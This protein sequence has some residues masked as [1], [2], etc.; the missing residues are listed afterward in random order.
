MLSWYMSFF[1]KKGK[2][3]YTCCYSTL[4]LGKRMP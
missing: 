4:R 1:L 3:I 2:K